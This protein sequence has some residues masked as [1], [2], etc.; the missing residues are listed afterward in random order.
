AQT[1]SRSRSLGDRQA[2]PIQKRDAPP[3][4]AARASASTAFRSI[5]FSAFTPVSTIADCGQYAQSS[6]QP[7]VFIDSKVE[8]CTSEESKF[9]RCTWPA[10]NIR[11]GNGAANSA[12]TCSRGQYALETSV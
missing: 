2:A 8:I 3:A 5:S 12:R 7:P 4:L 10:R 11:S 1:L 9:S 6:G